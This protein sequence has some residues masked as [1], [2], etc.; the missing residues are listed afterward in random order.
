MLLTILVKEQSGKKS[1][2]VK[3]RP[4]YVKVSAWVLPGLMKEYKVHLKPV[5]DATSFDGIIDI[6]S[7]ETNISHKLIKARNRKFDVV[8][9]RQLFFYFAKKYTRSS[10]RAIGKFAGNRDHSTVL[11]GIQSINDRIDTDPDFRERVKK[12]ELKII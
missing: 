11:Y 4:K 7:A 12:V 10:A 1:H 5:L 9:A 6:V 8:L 2:R 3:E